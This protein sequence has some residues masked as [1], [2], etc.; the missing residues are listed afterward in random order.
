MPMNQIISDSQLI[1]I[2]QHFRVSAGPGAGKTYWLVEHIKN[3]LHR[4][5]RLFKSRKIA[6]ITYTNIAAETILSRLGTSSDRVEVSTIHSFLYRHI[7][8]PY[9]SFIATDYSLNVTEMDGHDE[10]I[11][12]F[13]KFKEWADKTSQVYLY[14]DKDKTKARKKTDKAIEALMN[15]QWQFDQNNNLII[16]PNPKKPWLGKVD[17]NVS[18]RNNSYIE[19][20]KLYWQDGVLHHDDVLFFSYQLL[21]R[22]PFILQALRSKFPYFFIDE[23]QDTNP[24]QTVILKQIGQKETI[25][26]VIG[27]KAQSIYGFQGAEP[28]QFISF[29]LPNI[30]DYQMGE[31]RRSTNQIIDVLNHIRRDDIEQIKFR[32]VDGEQ[33]IIFIGEMSA[34]LRKAKAICNGEQVYS[35]SRDNITSNAMKKEINGISLDHQLFE[36]LIEQDSPSSGNNYRSRVVITCVKAAEFAREGKFGD[37]IKELER[38]FRDIEDKEKRKAEALKYIQVLLKKYNEYYEKPLYDFY[39]FIKSNIKPKISTLTARNSAKPLYGGHTY[40]Q[41]A[42]CVKIPDDIS[43]HKTVHKA[44]GDEFDNVL[45]VLNK[46]ANLEFMLNPN[47]SATNEE[48][49]EQRINYVAVSRA[50]NRLFINTPTLSEENIPKLKDMFTIDKV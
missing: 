33:P 5:R 12:S 8:K 28:S 29:S 22:Y 26:G 6:C 7:V 34:S 50:K 45:L 18:I 24:I 32:N 4:S 27:D 40:Q 41:F 23:F 46:E 21:Q 25:V 31:N 20:K 43:L 16:K 47:I 2:E 42:C 30:V 44:K 19:L 10:I 11:I 17:N 37:A 48:G 38:I 15:L 14:Q 49:E 13:G 39:C 36:K 35:L 3:V 9:V 1:N